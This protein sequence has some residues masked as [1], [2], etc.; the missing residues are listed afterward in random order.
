M[1]R[2]LHI[3]ILSC[4]KATFFIEKSYVQP[5]S[6]TE[7]LQLRLHL[8]ICD[9]CAKYKKQSAIIES[10]LKSQRQK[11]ALPKELKLS[12]DFKGLMKSRIDQKL[13]KD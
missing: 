9:K 4:K 10:L 11:A 7:K 6:L 8:V 5:L 1:K 2:L 3:V 12:D 13:K